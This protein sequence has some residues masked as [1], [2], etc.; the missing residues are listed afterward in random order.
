MKLKVY[1]WEKFEKS[2]M[3]YV[4]FALVLIAIIGL[5]LRKQNLIWVIV[6][7]FIVWAY[8]YYNITSNQPIT[9]QIE[10]KHL[11]INH[12]TYSRRNFSA[13]SIEIDKK[14]E[15]ITNLVLISPKWHQIYTIYDNTENAR[16]FFIELD[17]YLPMIGEYD[18]SFL[19]KLARILKL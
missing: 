4:W 14:T 12:K 13:Y 15:E 7:F 18:Q 8:L 10:E 2:K 5:S 1:N 6:L 11:T 19:E 9:I 17:K 16:D 3:R